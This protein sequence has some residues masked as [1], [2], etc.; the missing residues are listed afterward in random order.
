M[1]VSW[2]KGIFPSRSWGRGG[3]GGLQCILECPQ[4]AP[5]F[6]GDR[7]K[8]PRVLS[9]TR[10]TSHSVIKFYLLSLWLVIAPA[11][12]ASP[13]ATTSTWKDKESQIESELAKGHSPADLPPQPSA[14][15]LA[16]KPSA[17]TTSATESPSATSPASSS[18][19]KATTA[20]RPL[21]LGLGKVKGHFVAIYLAILH[22][23]LCCFGV[24][25]RAE[26]HKAKPRRRKREDCVATETTFPFSEQNSR[27]L[28]LQHLCHTTL[29]WALGTRDASAGVV[30]TGCSLYRYCLAPCCE[31]TR[32]LT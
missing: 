4:K 2:L 16:S 6:G 14:A 5:S 8:N 26:V 13:E 32:A 10:R 12:S 18:T 7:I 28:P 9:D 23:F 30:F 25:G 15:A 29:K 19:A 22:G 21:A 1:A 20:T 24:F 3:G 17:A 11:T 31:E 27:P